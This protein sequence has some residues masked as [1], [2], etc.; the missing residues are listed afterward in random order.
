MKTKAQIQ[1]DF[2]EAKKRASE[3]EEIASDLSNVSKRDMENT[4]GNIAAAWKGDSARQYLGKAER[5]QNDIQKTAGELQKVASTIRVV[6]QN[7]Y[8][9]EMEALRIAMQRDGGGGGGFR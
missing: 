4:M 2:A 3:I 7:I 5:L 8:N 6:A 9:A 1:M